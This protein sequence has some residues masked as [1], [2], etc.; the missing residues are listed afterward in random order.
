MPLATQTARPIRPAADSGG[1]MRKRFS[2]TI[3]IAGVCALTLLTA[4]TP[5]VAGVGSGPTITPVMGGLNA[6]RGI[7][8]D[9]QGSMYV[10]ESGAAG[11]GDAGL[12]R[13]GKVSKFAWGSHSPAWTRTFT[14]FYAT[15]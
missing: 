9:G 7:A 11:Q 10:S 1:I 14:S 5:S 6:T 2:G 3:G 15:Q 13:T 4:G 12:T 8:F